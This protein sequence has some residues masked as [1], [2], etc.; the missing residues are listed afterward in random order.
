[1]AAPAPWEYAVAF[2]ACALLTVVITPL[3]LRY[4]LRRRLLDQPSP[5]KAQSEAVPYLGGIAIAV[6]FSVV[7]MGA[8]LYGHSRGDLDVAAVTLGLALGLAVMGLIDDL[9]GLPAWLRLVIQAGAGLAA[10]ANGTQAHLAGAGTVL[11]VV[12]TVVWLVGITNAFNL[13]DNMDGLSAGVAAIAAFWLFVVGLVN[14]QHLV[15][16]LALALVGCALGF[17]RHNFAPAR[18]YM[19]DA[20]S[21]FIGFLLA[22]LALRLRTYS[23]LRLSFLVP[24]LIL[25]V[26]IFDT[27]LVVMTRLLHRRSPMKGGL[28]HTS[29]RLVFL[30]LPVR[31]SVGL[32]YAVTVATGSLGVIASRMSRDTTILLGGWVL[33]VALFLGVALGVVPVYE[34]S[35]RRRFMIQ[36]VR[37][38]QPEAPPEVA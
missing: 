28:D 26:P 14:G 25:A 5:I 38:H 24:V 15:S 20:G 13:L 19:G 18:I 10:Y 30:G 33:A 23:A 1:M 17:L 21:M 29:H 6:V 12:V 36:E 4:A 7:V 22:V 2:L 27:A 9:R 16:I 37:S 3:M 11:D 35:R 34:N 8:A 32:I 31:V